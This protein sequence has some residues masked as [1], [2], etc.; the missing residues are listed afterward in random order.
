MRHVRQTG[1][2]FQPAQMEYL[3]A[4]FTNP[5]RRSDYGVT[6]GWA[7]PV[8]CWATDRT[9][10][11]HYPA[12]DHATLSLVMAGSAIERTDLSG[13]G[14]SCDNGQ[15]QVMLYPGGFDRA[16][17]SN[18]P[19]Q[20]CQLYLSF[21]MLRAIAEEDRGAPV[22][23]LCLTTDR[24]LLRDPTLRRMA[25]DYVLAASRPTLNVSAME[26]DSRAILMSLHIVRSYSNRR[27][28]ANRGPKRGLSAR[29]L[30][31][32]NQHI[33]EHLSETLRVSDLAALVGL[34]PHVF[35]L[36]FRQATGLSPHKFLVRARLERARDLVVGGG[37]LAEIAL[38][39][40]FSSQQHLTAAFSDAFGSSPGRYRQDLKTFSSRKF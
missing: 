28:A 32:L 8:G 12:N 26:M 25:E 33:A 2:A 15:G 40:G 10:D 19:T 3:N 31:V 4:N 29:S 9:F 13:D 6:E 21:D 39:C 35:T 38:E 11:L 14:W 5:V 24:I 1:F 22:S 34:P 16:Y 27:S 20:F 18:G 36:A 30:T 23:A 7:I 17:A 37:S